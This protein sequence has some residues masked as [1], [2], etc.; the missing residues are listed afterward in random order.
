MGLLQAD[1]V[2]CVRYY[3]CGSFVLCRSVSTGRLSDKLLKAVFGPQLD[4]G[5]YDNLYADRAMDITGMSMQ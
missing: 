2:S 1:Y 3:S 4:R 5:C